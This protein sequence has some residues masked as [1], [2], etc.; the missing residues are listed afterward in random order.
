MR[1]IRTPHETENHST[2]TNNRVDLIDV[3]EGLGQDSVMHRFVFACL[4]FALMAQ[5]AG[6]D[7]ETASDGLDSASYT[8]FDIVPEN[9]QNNDVFNVVV[10]GDSVAWGTG[11]KKEEK[12]SYLVAKWLAKQ[13]GRPVHVKVLAHTGATI[14]SSGT[15]SKD[16]ISH[17]ELTSG[18][19][20]LMEQAD[21]L[22]STNDIDSNDI[23]FVLVSGGANDVGLDTLF[24]LNYGVLNPVLDI[25]SSAEDIRKKAENIRSTM[26]N[27]IFKLLM[28]PDARIIVTGYYTGISKDSKGITEVVATI[29]PES[30]NVITKGYQKLDG[31]NKGQVVEKSNVF[32]QTANESLSI[33]VDDANEAMHAADSRDL[34]YDRAAFVPIFFPPERCYGTD[35]SWLWKMEQDYVT[36]TMKTND[37]MFETRVALLKKLDTYCECEPCSSKTTIISQAATGF[38]KEPIS[39][40]L[41]LPPIS[42]N[43]ES[44]PPVVS[45]IDC[46]KYQRNKLDAVGHPNVEGAKNYSESIIREIRTTWPTWLYPTVEAFDVPSRSLTYGESLE[47]TYTVSDNGGSGLKQVE[48]WRTQDKD[49][50]PEDPI[51]TKVLADEN[52][53]IGSFTDSPPAPGKYWYGVHVVDNAGNWNDER[54]SNTNGQP[55]S[56]EPE[57]VEVK[58]SQEVTLTLYVHDG[59]AD[60]SV[61]SG[62]EVTGQDAVGSSFFQTTDANGF[63]ILTGSPGNWQFTATKPGYVINSWSQE[64]G[65]TCT[66]HAFLMAEVAMGEGVTSSSLICTLTGHSYSVESVAFSPDGQTLASGS[67]DNTVKL[68]DVASRTE[69]ATL[70][71]HSS[72]VKS[73]AFSPDGQTLASGSNDCTVKLWDVASRTEVATLG[74]YS[75]DVTSVVF[76]PDGRTLA[77]GSY[78]RTVKLW[79]V[80]SRTEIATMKGQCMQSVAFSPDGQILA[81]G[82]TDNTVTLWDVASRTEAAT[83]GSCSSGVTY[84]HVAFSPDGQILA[85]GSSDNFFIGAVTLWDVASR[86]EVATLSDHSRGVGSVAFSPDGQTLAFGGDDNTVKLWDVASRTEV[87]SLSGHSGGVTSV[88]FS[89]DGHTL[90]SGSIDGTVQL[91]NMG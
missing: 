76:S 66:K 39:L 36:K 57:E 47:I 55:S 31:E 8:D 14:E 35:Q 54:N 17:P 30:Q 77:S 38:D 28:C 19:P 43:A 34:P 60:G 64:I 42:E 52:G 71:G 46:K 10:I 53:P 4:V 32:S 29:R 83:L 20:T 67:V 18:S 80:T 59:S 6:A 25:G 61:L 63:V 12:Y 27:I 65:A 72:G 37:N 84:V 15:D 88:A 90:A 23:D 81:S 2:D 16:Q 22:L 82:S 21:E 44:T 49:I 75:S 70:S 7:G 45:G 58:S 62:A 73:V 51:Q 78:D 3:A 5:G 48:L 41:N 24:K 40:V 56:F 74:S 11:L 9:V 86:T 1:R 87:G 91:W 69:V 13:L 33:A 68:W 50:W 26:Y 89:P 85:S 79:D